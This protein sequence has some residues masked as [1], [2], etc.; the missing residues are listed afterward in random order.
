MR[1]LREWIGGSQPLPPG[2]IQQQRRWSTQVARPRPSAD[3]HEA[4]LDA[5]A[6]IDALE[7][8]RVQEPLADAIG[9]CRV[10]RWFR[11]ER[12]RWLAFK[13]APL[14]ERGLVWLV[15]EKLECV[16]GDRAS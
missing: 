9:G 13:A 4:D 12:D 8:P 1:G 3:S 11:R 16:G 2:R 5:E 10:F 14:R 15:A 7:D 6:F